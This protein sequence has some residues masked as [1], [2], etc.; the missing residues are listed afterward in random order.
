MSE[1]GCD[2]SGMWSK[3]K[4]PALARSFFDMTDCPVLPSPG[5]SWAARSG[6]DEWINDCLCV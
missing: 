1:C 6:E 4:W 5:L 3:R 2:L